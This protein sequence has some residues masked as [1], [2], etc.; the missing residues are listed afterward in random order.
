MA[1]SVTQDTTFFELFAVLQ[2]VVAR[3]HRDLPE[4]RQDELVVATATSMIA[5]GDVRFASRK[6]IL[7]VV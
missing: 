4:Q 2:D 1:S 6:T 3:E 7:V 5:K